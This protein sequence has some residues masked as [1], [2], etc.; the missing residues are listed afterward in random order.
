[1]TNPRTI[2]PD[3]RTVIVGVDPHKHVHVAVAIDTWGIRLGKTD[4]AGAR[5]SLVRA[6][7]RDRRPR[8]SPGSTHHPDLADAA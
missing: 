2:Q 6:L 7:R 1:M 5:P 4:P 8:P 3:A